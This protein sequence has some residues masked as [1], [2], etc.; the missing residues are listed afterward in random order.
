MHAQGGIEG[1]LGV[2]F[3]GNRRP[4]QRKDAISQGLGH[5]PVIA[6]DSVHHELQSGIDDC[7]GFFGIESFNQRSRAFEVSK[8]GGDSF[9]LAIAA[10]PCFH[11][12]LLGPDALGEVRRGVTNG[13]SV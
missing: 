7:T 6:M 4:K 8:E 10:S 12:S 1:A 3:V 2:V 9:A 11:S 5:I 13:S